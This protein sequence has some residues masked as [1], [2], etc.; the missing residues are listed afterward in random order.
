[1]N[2]QYDVRH[3]LTLLLVNPVS[4][5]ILEMEFDSCHSA[6]VPNI[7]FSIISR[8]T[9]MQLLVYLV[10]LYVKIA[11]LQDNVPRVLDNKQD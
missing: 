9:Q 10:I 3:V 1:M 8:T 4:E 11:M 6:N 7:N 2:V 5:I